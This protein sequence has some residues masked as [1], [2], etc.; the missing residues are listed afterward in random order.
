MEQ[1]IWREHVWKRRTVADL[2]EAY[3]K[4]EHTIRRILDRAE[5]RK[6]T[7]CE[8]GK[9]V[10][11]FDGTHIGGD[12]LLVGRSPSMKANLGWA[13]IPK[14]TKEYYAGLRRH[15]EQ[16]GFIITAAVLDGRTGI[17]RVFK[18]IPVQICQ[19]HQL[20]TVKRKLTLKPETEAGRELLSLAF[21]LAR[22]DEKLF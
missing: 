7:P 8:S 22:T 19:F 10:V 18:D 2:R 9:T 13:W 3:Q 16:K 15:I 5:E 1:K 20:Q 17:P 12:I 6:S 11:I 14:E 4:G 21:S